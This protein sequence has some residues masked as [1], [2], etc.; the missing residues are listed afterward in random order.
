MTSESSPSVNVIRHDPGNRRTPGHF[1]C[2]A[3]WEGVRC[4]WRREQV[5]R[6]AAVKHVRKKHG[7]ASTCFVDR[8]GTLL[9]ADRGAKTA[10]GM[11][12]W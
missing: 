5:D 4:D 2:T 1:E 10:K 12:R 11:V 7:G 9:S 8:D 6:N 3:V